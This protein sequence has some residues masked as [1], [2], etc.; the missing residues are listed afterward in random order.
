MLKNKKQPTFAVTAR[1]FWKVFSTMLRSRIVQA[2]IAAFA[3]FR[4]SAKKASL[5]VRVLAFT[6]S[7]ACA[8]SMSRSFLNECDIG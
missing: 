1:F 2:E 7:L 5:A 4:P 8:V 6:W 3:Y